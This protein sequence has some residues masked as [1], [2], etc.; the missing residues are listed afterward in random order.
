LDKVVGIE[1]C[2][3]LDSLEFKPQ[4]GQDFPQSIQTGLGAHPVSYSVGSTCLR[5]IKQPGHGLD[6]PPPSSADVKEGEELYL[7]SPFGPS[8]PVLEGT[9]CSCHLSS[10]Q[11]AKLRNSH[12]FLARPQEVTDRWNLCREYS[13]IS[14]L[15]K[16]LQPAVRMLIFKHSVPSPKQT[17]RPTGQSYLTW[18]TDITIVHRQNRREVIKYA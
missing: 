8:W 4:W 9:C 1:T 6:H 17:Q 2:Y 14:H 7:H 5:G 11:N 3:R 12:D 16:T 10:P 13:F 18:F 15:L